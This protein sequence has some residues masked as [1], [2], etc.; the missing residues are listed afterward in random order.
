MKT[1]NFEIP[2]YDDTKHAEVLDDIHIG[3]YG[4]KYRVLDGLIMP[5][6]ITPDRYHLSRTIQ[7]RNGD[8]CFIS[9]PKAGSTWLSYIILLL[10]R[11]GDIPP[12]K[13][14][15]DCFHWVASSWPYP[16]SKDELDALP[17]PRIFK[18]HMSYNMALGG[19]PAENP[20]KYIYIARNPK[21]VAVSYYHFESG[22]KW[23]GNYSGPW[24]HW[25]KIFMEGRVQ[26]GDWFDHVL[27]W[28]KHSDNGN[29]LFLKYED[30]MNNFETQLEKIAQF[31]HCPLTTDVISKIQ[32][33]TS[34]TR[35]KQDKFSNLHEIAELGGFFRK[36][37]IGSWKERFTVAQNELFDALYAAR[38]KDTGLEF[39]FE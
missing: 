23:S 10:T 18:S 6:Y 29:I 32:E 25:L 36:G 33:K 2:E 37:Q 16:R 4:Y 5:P 24:E 39:K 7:T 31:L 27:S 3:E 21:D 1:D 35:M 20:C 26:R 22:K 11:K 34:F 17:S 19:N 28:W 13:T 38:M 8:I 15:R 30:L 14:L 9:Y 12:E